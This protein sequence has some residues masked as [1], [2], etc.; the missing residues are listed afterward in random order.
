MDT[1]AQGLYIAATDAAS[2][3]TAIALGV[4]EAMSRRV[5]RL[6]VFRPV[7]AGGPTP[8]PVVELLRTRYRVDEPY[9]ACVGTTYDA[10]HIDPTRAVEDIVERYRD[11]ASRCEA[12]LVVG[13]DFTEAGTATEFGRASCRER[14]Y[15]PV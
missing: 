1:G 6:G 2:G 15:H 9:E 4:A 5:Q 12:V 10:V 14:V 11:L 7:V 13:T 3:K 8:D